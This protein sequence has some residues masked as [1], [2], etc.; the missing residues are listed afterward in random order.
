MLWPPDEHLPASAQP[1]CGPAPSSH[2]RVEQGTGSEVKSCLLTKVFQASITYKQQGR[3]EL[4]GK[5]SAGGRNAMETH[6]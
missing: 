1:H 3:E 6:S 2:P 4:K 5:S